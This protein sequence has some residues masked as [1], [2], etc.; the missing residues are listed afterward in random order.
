M[1]GN[2][3]WHLL[4]H[5]AL[6]PIIMISTFASAST[7]IEVSAPEQ[8]VA[9]VRSATEVG[10]SWQ[11][12][13]GVEGIAGYRIF[14]DG[15]RIGRTKVT[16]YIDTT[17]VPNSEHVYHVTAF[18][19]G[20]NKLSSQPSNIDI[21]KTLSSD[22][23]DGMRNGSIIRVGI[24]RLV[25]HC[26]TN[27][28]NAIADSELDVCMDKLIDHYTLRQG[29]D[30]MQA[31][32]ARYR[33]QEDAQLIELGKRLFF[34]KALSQNYDTSCASCHHPA[35]GCGSD[36]LSLSIGVNAENADLM[37]LGRSD[38]TVVPS[39]GRNSPQICNSAL[40]V[41]SM[42]WDQRVRLREANR[43]SEVG[44]VSTADIQT[45][46]LEVTRLMNEEV[47]NT[48]PLRLLMAQAHFPITAPAEM[49]D[50]AGFESPQ[51]YREFIAQ[52]LSE[53]WKPYFKAAFGDEQVNFLRIARAMSAY[54]ASFLFIDNP[55]FNYI[56]G[57]NDKLS[58][59]EKRG[60]L[61]FYTGAGCANCHDG[62]MFTP[63]RTRGPLY[64]QIGAHG[65][66]DGN[67]KNQFRM[68]SL[69]NVGI[70]APYGDKGVFATLER[71]IEHY[72]D[73]TGS[74]ERFYGE[75]E[76]CGLPQ[77]QHL[78]TEQCEHI[79]GD[80][81]DYVLALNAQNRAASDRSDDAI[82]RGFTPQQVS[83]LAAFL[84]ALTDPKALAGSHEI[85]VLIPSRD[86]GPDGHQFDAVNKEGNA[87]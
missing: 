23:N 64:P 75:N 66:A 47:A 39:V 60:A 28:L 12:P 14:R 38:G 49:G 59:E 56:E 42:F 68:P 29:L 22:D 35:Q 33:R 44:T 5:V 40:W 6:V 71:V 87:L 84:R 69:L 16:F 52:R 76:T 77:F 80:A 61:F 9:K 62:V 30:D 26:G 41:D 45:P 54:Q 55:F 31:Y 63:E 72:S 57:Q 70:T 58:E 27:D 19:R 83:Y 51:A 15:K 18:T 50:P 4:R 1:F 78:N 48:D 36:G 74:L 73:V 11:A 79:V 17:A 34:S 7:P 82:I 67:F 2:S 53:Q 13:T 21:V 37:G 86:G 3:Y 8:L 24:A 43:D 20:K 32:V 85:N 10:L 81:G 46:E 25:D 65:V